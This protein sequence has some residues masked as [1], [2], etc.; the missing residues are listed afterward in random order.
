MDISPKALFGKRG[1]NAPTIPSPSA[2]NAPSAPIAPSAP[3]SVPNDKIPHSATNPIVIESGDV[4]Y[5][6]PSVD[7]AAV[8]DD[9]RSTH[10]VGFIHGVSRDKWELIPALVLWIFFLCLSC[11]GYACTNDQSPCSPP[12]GVDD[13]DYAHGYTNPNVGGGVVMVVI[14][15]IAVWINGFCYSKS[16]SHLINVVK[17]SE[18]ASL[19]QSIVN[20]R[21]MITLHM[22]CSHLETRTVQVSDNN[23][24][25]RTEQRTESVTTHTAKEM[26]QFTDCIDRSQPLEAAGDINWNAITKLVND[27]QIISSEYE[28][29]KTRWKNYH[30]RD[31]HNDF[32]VEEAV[33]GLSSNVL[34]LSPEAEQWAWLIN[35]PIYIVCVL[36]GYLGV[37]YRVLL[38]GISD[39][40]EYTYV[41][42]IGGVQDMVPENTVNINVEWPGEDVMYGD[43]PERAYDGG[44]ARFDDRH[45]GVVNG[46]HVNISVV[47]NGGQEEA[48]YE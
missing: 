22:R 3:P 13:W 29:V 2:P 24:N 5:A 25:M 35:V 44:G 45:A 41:K 6:G 28:V 31:Q 42:E 33:P 10:K 48:R 36:S 12:E 9:R 40:M 23:G 8:Y 20:E 7:N 39:K 18:M 4:Q 43:R 14:G 47:V 37:W 26:V 16:L 1:T 46:A 32:R 21:P 38:S 15:Y 34:L 17:N 19:H 27:L 30:S 11:M